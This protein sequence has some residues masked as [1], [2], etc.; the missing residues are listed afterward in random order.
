M[1]LMRVFATVVVL[2]WTASVEH[3]HLSVVNFSVRMQK[4]ICKH[5]QTAYQVST[6]TERELSAGNQ[7]LRGLLLAFH[8]QGLRHAVE[9]PESF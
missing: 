3:D 1:T 6:A 9:A 2:P 5:I 7:G 8:G 4:K